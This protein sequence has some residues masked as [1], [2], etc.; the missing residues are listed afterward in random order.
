MPA[1]SAQA[2][3]TGQPRDAADCDRVIAA[4]DEGDRAR[5]D[6][7]PDRVLD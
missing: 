3:V 6:H 7:L 4:K 2:K 5:S 1:R